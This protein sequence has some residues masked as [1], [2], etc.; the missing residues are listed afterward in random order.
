MVDTSSGD[1]ISQ[2]DLLSVGVCGG[3]AMC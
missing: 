1:E 3:F 2:A